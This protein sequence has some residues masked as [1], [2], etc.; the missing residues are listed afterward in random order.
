MA[1]SRNLEYYQYLILIHGRFAGW[2]SH[3][4]LAVTSVLSFLAVLMTYYGVN[5]LLGT[6]LHS[7]GRGTGGLLYV[8]L[9]LVFE[10]LVIALA[11]A[12]KVSHE[13]RTSGKAL[14]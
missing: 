7:Y 3:F 12:R 9:F 5:F 1:L 8:I 11:F 10:V 13:D 6:G 14:S 2:L 4:G